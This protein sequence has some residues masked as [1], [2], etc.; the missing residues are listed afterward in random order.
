MTEEIKLAAERACGQTVTHLE[1][2]PIIETLRGK[3]LWDGLVEV[4]CVA[5]PPPER[6][7]GWSEDGPS[8]EPQYIAVLGE[9]PIKTPLDAVR[10]WLV[11]Q[12]RK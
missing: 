2:V 12:I 10:A 3:V 6:V 1:D 7:Y 11:S 8:G 4:Y 9:P 5:K